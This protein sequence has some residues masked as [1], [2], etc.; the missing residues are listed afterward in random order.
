M[1]LKK[2]KNNA[3]EKLKK[4]ILRFLSFRRLQKGEERQTDWEDLKAA[5]AEA[6]AEATEEKEEGEAAAR[7]IKCLTSSAQLPW[8]AQGDFTEAGGGGRRDLMKG[9]G[10]GRGKWRDDGDDDTAWLA[11]VAK[12]RGRGELVDEVSTSP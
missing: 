11:E 9:R 3:P 5:A 10:G 8:E 12:G 6:E 7:A 1:S 2:K 4:N